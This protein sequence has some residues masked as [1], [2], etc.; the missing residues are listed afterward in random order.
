[1]NFIGNIG[2]WQQN[3]RDQET[4]HTVMNTKKDDDDEVGGGVV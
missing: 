4:S 1:M 2:F 3:T